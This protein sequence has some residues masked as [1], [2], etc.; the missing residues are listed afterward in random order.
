M[1]VNRHHLVATKEAKS[2]QKAAKSGQ[3]A[4]K[5]GQKLPKPAKTSQNLPKSI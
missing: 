3:K 5:S 1:K 4:A 2:C